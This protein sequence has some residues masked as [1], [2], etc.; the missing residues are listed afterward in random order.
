MIYDFV[1]K[2]FVYIWEELDFYLLSLDVNL[3]WPTLF[4]SRGVVI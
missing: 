1:D 3:H 4:I 2:F